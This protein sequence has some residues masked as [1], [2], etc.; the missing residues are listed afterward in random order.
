MDE[1]SNQSAPTTPPSNH[2]NNELIEEEHPNES[3]NTTVSED[4]TQM[5]QTSTILKRNGNQTTKSATKSGEHKPKPKIHPKSD[6]S[7]KDESLSYV[8]VQKMLSDEGAIQWD[9]NVSQ[10][11]QELMCQMTSQVL[12]HAKSTSEHRESSVIET[13][14]VEEA[15]NSLSNFNLNTLILFKF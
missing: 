10:Q 6:H 5:P 4:V 11:I 7:K 8:V 1:S 13:E 2:Q 15:L 3:I 9:K 14:D 12:D